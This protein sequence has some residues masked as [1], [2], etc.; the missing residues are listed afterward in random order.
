MAL[1]SDDTTQ[2]TEAEILKNWEDAWKREE[3]K[4]TA[5][6]VRKEF[7]F[8]RDELRHLLQIGTQ[9]ALAQQIMNIAKT[10]TTDILNSVVLPRVGVTP[11]P[12]L[13]ILYDYNSGRLMVWA[14][15][16][17]AKKVTETPT[18]TAVEVE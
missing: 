8:S 16:Q 15:K 2:P 9:E 3:L 4:F 5:P 14:P 17:E 12:D 13:N 1:P 10:A 11:K 7:T 6:Y 18:P